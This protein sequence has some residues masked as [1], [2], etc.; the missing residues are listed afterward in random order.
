MVSSSV[1]MQRALGVASAGGLCTRSWEEVAR[2]Y[3]AAHPG[4][5]MTVGYARKTH[6]VAMRK[7]RDRAAAMGLVLD[8]LEGGV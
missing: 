3:N 6:A 4:E 5:A 2:A 7:L 1:G 8:E